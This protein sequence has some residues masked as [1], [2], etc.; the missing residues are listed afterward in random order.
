[1]LHILNVYCVLGSRYDVGFVNVYCA[2]DAQPDA[3]FRVSDI[4]IYN[5][6]VPDCRAGCPV[7]LYYIMC[8]GFAMQ[9]NA[10]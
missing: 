6:P 3:G 10:T 7:L 1:M 4:K 2:F 5:T 8:A 9:Y